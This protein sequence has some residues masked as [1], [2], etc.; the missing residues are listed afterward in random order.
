MPVVVDAMGGDYAPEEV[1]KGA[2]AAA[3]EFEIDVIL[4]GDENKINGCNED[5]SSLTV[6][7]ASD[8]IGMNEHPAKAIR[9]KP[10]SSIAVAARIARETD[11]GSLVSAGHTGAVMAAAVFTFGRIEGIER[12][13]IACVMPT[14]GKDTIVLDVGANVDCKPS[15]LEKFGILGSAYAKHVL[16][17][18]KPLVGLLNI[19][20]EAKKG[21]EQTFAAYKLLAESTHLNFAGN[22]E[23]AGV[24]SGA[25]DVIVTDGFAGNIFLKSSEAISNILQSLIKKE[26]STMGLSPAQLKQ[27][28]GTLARFSTKNPQ[29]AGAPLLGVDGTC[30]IAHGGSKAETIKHCIVMADNFQKS[31]A[32]QFMKNQNNG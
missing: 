29:Y 26:V 12:P 23:P 22:I 30:V 10:D 11:N 14:T 28:F 18:E 5:L 2:V 16:N 3:K 15:H 1:V 21:N 32:L 20:E 25:A 17:A 7:H 6:K 24:Y 4:V 19:G 27:F 31:N 9:R 8:I 13:G